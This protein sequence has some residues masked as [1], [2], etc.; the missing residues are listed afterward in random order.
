[1]KLRFQPL[2]LGLALLAGPAYAQ[3]PAVISA[4]IAEKIS[5]KQITHQTI[6][7]IQMVEGKGLAGQMKVVSGQIKGVI[8]KTQQ[9]HDT[10]YSSLLQI[11]SGV[12]NYRRVREIYDAQ[13]GMIQQ[14]STVQ[15]SLARKGLTTAQVSEAGKT[16]TALLTENVGLIG[17]LVGVLSA[18]RAKMTDPERLE[19]INN[20]ADRMNDQQELFTYYTSKCEALAQQQQQA[21]ADTKS[22][23]VLTGG[24]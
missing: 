15:S 5:R 1:M 9:L 7:G 10:W 2:A 18:N 4:P 24:K 12:R 20:I 23:L 19:F 22:L 6:T 17:D 16:Y 14:Y 8:D 21:A 13:A 11:S 3:L